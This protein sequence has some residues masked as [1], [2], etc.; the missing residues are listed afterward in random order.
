M[1]NNMDFSVFLEVKGLIPS[2][3]FWNLYVAKSFLSYEVT[4]ILLA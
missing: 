1:Q 2:L 4:E 3:S